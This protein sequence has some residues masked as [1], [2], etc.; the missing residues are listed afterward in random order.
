MT[1]SQLDCGKPVRYSVLDASFVTGNAEA[2]SPRCASGHAAGGGD[3]SV[4]HDERYRSL[5]QDAIALSVNYYYPNLSDAAVVLA[6]A[7]LELFL[8]KV[9]EYQLKRRKVEE[10]ITRF[11]LN[12]MKPNMRAYGDLL[13]TLGIKVKKTKEWE[14]LWEVSRIRDDVVHRGRYPSDE[15]VLLVFERIARA[16][17]ILSEHYLSSF[18]EGSKARQEPEEI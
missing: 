14:K 8:S 9:I 12:D 10:G 7:S 5:F 17:T 13:E 15:E 6:H 18:D 4:G 2:E 3:L 11:I 1:C 16:F